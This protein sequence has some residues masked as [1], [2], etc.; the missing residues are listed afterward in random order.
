LTNGA[1][2]IKKV[3]YSKRNS[4]QNQKTTQ[5]MGK[6][7]ASYL[8]D[9]ALLSRICKELQN[10]NSKRTNN[11]INKWMNKFTGHFS[12]EIQMINEYMK[13]CSTSFF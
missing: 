4:Y 9:K 11:S 3:L 7:L 12:E 6:N 1:A 10:L 2:S 8:R 5:R 13:K